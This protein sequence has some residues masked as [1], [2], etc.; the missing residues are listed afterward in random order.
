MFSLNFVPF[1][2]YVSSAQVKS[3][4]IIGQTCFVAP[5]RQPLGLY[6]YGGV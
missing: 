3:K 1:T 4:N 6:A 5:T 2:I